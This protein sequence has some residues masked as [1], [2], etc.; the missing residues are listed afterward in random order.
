MKHKRVKK[1]CVVGLGYVGMPLAI[2]FSKKFTV[3]GFDTDS[4]RIEELRRGIDRT[5]TTTRRTL[6]KSGITFSAQAEVLRDADFII[7]TVPTPIT[8]FNKPDLR[9]LKEAS[10]TIGRNMKRGVTVVYESTVY[11]GVTEEVCLPI[12]EEESGMECGKDFLIGY[13]PERISPGDKSRVENIK[14]IVAGCNH[15]ALEKIA[16]LYTS[17]IKAG[18]H[19]APNIKVAEM[20][21][22]I[23]NIQRDV[24]IAIINELA[25]I[26]DRLGI[27]THKVIEAASTKWNF[28]KYYPG[29]VGGH[30]IG[31]DPYYLSYKAKQVGYDAKV[32]AAGR[33]INNRMAYFIADKVVDMLK[34]AG[35]RIKETKVAILGFTFKEN[36][37]DTRNSKAV[38]VLQQLRRRGIKTYV[39]DP[40]LPEKITSNEFSV[41]NTQF[42]KLK[43][44][45]GVVMFSPHAA[46]K[47]LTLNKLK[48]IMSDNPALFDVKGFYEQKEAELLGF[49]YKRL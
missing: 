2:A 9:P 3:T 43:Q 45:D 33:E 20:A 39:H 5:G 49:I 8:R 29:A 44:I 31:V 7:V 27:D 36:V 19:K 37:P 22:I 1:I 14:K 42:K 23:E 41:E 24:N 28:H 38:V 47:N 48:K 15:E 17:I 25:L 46:F 32:I 12:L 26:C 40:L 6:K 11:P 30:C 21:K 10:A 4:N 16:G 13:S 35:K 34:K 18:I